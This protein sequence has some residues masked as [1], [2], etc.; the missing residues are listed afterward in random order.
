VA[1]RTADC[2]ARDRARRV[3]ASVGLTDS[4]STLALVAPGGRVVDTWTDARRCGASVGGRYAGRIRL[5]G[6]GVALGGSV[7]GLPGP[8]GALTAAELAG[9]APVRHALAVLVPARLLAAGSRWPAVRADGT[10][11]AVTAGSGLRLGALLALR[12]AQAAQL[13]PA[14]AAG[15]R[16]VAALRDHGAYVAGVAPGDALDL[17]VLRPAGATTGGSSAPRLPPALRADLLAAAA[18][19]SIVDDNAP[20]SVGG[21]VVR[22]VAAAAP[23]APA[24]P[25]PAPAPAP[26]APP[27][28]T[29]LTSAAYESTLE[30]TVDVP[31]APP[32]AVA[33]IVALAVALLVV[34]L[35]TGRAA[36]RAFAS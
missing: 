32:A 24:T 9:R 27:G 4:P 19:L 10:Q 25:A 26:P 21:R 8:G 2:A 5:D 7:P 16:L 34:G 28:Q 14:S 23:P 20:A 18:D 11:S 30:L 33:G 12:P 1:V 36:V 6:L 13:R 31:A 3:P 22:R 29:P 35:H 15:R 17:R